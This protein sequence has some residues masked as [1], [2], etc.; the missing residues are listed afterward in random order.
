MPHTP[1]LPKRWLVF[2][3]SHL[4]DVALATGVLAHLAATRGWSFVFVTRTAFADVLRHNPHV[5]EIIA[6]REEDLAP[7]AFLRR[8]KALVAEYPGFGLLDLHGSLRSRLL[9]ALW[10]GPVLRYQKMSLERRLFLWSGARLAGEKLRALTVPQRYFMAVGKATGEAL[11]PPE[12]LL[13]RIWLTPEELAQADERL[14]RLFGADVRPIALHPYATHT[15]K[16]WPTDHWRALVALLDARKLPWIVIGRGA[17]LFPDRANDCT[18]ATSLRESCALLA[19]SRLLLTGDSGPMHL[20]SAVGTPVLALF[21]PTTREWGFFPAGPR[22]RVLER[23][24]L[25]CRPCSLH[26]RTPCTRRQECL[27]SISPEEALAAMEEMGQPHER[28]KL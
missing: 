11:P 4:G 1:Q 23:L 21:G 16:A 20:A 13:P 17:K 6:L 14:T 28:R 12:A 8:C 15:L 25:P 18:N 22:D 9:A 24:G 10:P 19:R 27:L 3:L 5:R 26:G 7:A 2:R